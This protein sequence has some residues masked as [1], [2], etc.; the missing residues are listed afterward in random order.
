MAPGVAPSSTAM[1]T[2]STLVVDRLNAG[3]MNRIAPEITAVS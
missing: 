2:S 3:R 1:T